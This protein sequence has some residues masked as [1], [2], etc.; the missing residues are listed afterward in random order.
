MDLLKGVTFEAGRVV[1]ELFD[2]RLVAVPLAW[3][4]KLRGAS[5]EQ[6]LLFELSPFGVHWSH[7][8]EDICVYGILNGGSPNRWDAAAKNE[9]LLALEQLL[10]EGFVEKI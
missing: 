4:P 3:F 6:R 1:F 5:E 2:G 10:E 7:L 8:D 9:M